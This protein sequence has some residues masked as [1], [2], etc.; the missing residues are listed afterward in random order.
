MKKT[1][2]IWIGTLIS[3]FFTACGPS[4]AALNSTATVAA[5]ALFATQTARAPTPTPT[6]TQTPTL[7]VTP[8]P[9][10]QPDPNAMIAWKDL[11]LP[12]DF[13]A[14]S[15]KGFGID[16]GAPGYTLNTGNTTVSTTIEGSFVF[17]DADQT[18]FVF[19]YTMKLPTKKDRDAFDAL[20][21]MLPDFLASVPGANVSSLPVKLRIDARG[22]T[23]TYK[24]SGIAWRKDQVAFRIGN[25]GTFVFVSHPDAV[26][27]VDVETVAQVYAD[28]IQKALQS[29]KL[30]SITPVEGAAWPSYDIVA[31]GFYPGERRAILLQG[32]VQI[33]TKKTGVTSGALGLD[34]TA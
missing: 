30:V 12:A 5:A 23:A 15:P 25:I 7:T 17:T 16:K 33:D 11:Q 22:A 20:L 4:Q 34:P 3:I 27:P 10:P 6:P 28:S 9:T 19:G 8:T 1:T 21:T 14:I 13:V 32:E 2:L 31:E 24:R 26:V 29:C 18:Q